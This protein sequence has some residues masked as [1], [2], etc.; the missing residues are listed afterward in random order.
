MSQLNHCI[1]MLNVERGGLSQIKTD[2]ANRC[3]R[4][5]DEL[6]NRLQESRNKFTPNA[7]VLQPLDPNRSLTLTNE[8]YRNLTESKRRNSSAMREPI[9]INLSSVGS[10]KFSDTGVLVV[11]SPTELLLDTR[12]L[13]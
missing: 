9:S 2:L 7:S 6:E 10:M 4:I 3:Q 11:D 1:A 8:V 5:F 12:V 13:Y